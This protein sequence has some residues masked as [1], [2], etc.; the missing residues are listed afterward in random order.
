MTRQML[1]LIAIWAFP[2]MASVQQ[3][4]LLPRSG[5]EIHRT[6]LTPAG[7][8]SF[9]ASARWTPRVTPIPRRRCWAWLH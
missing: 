1:W 5:F 7:E 9:Y 6:Q 4:P 8:S 3:G 2:L